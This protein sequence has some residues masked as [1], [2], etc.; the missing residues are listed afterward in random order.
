MSRISI[1]TATT[2]T[3]CSIPARVRRRSGISPGLG[4]SEAPWVRRSPA[5]GR[6]LRPAISTD[7]GKPDFVLYKA[8]TGQTVVW[9]LSNNVYAGAAFG[10][11]LAAGWSLAGVADFNRNGRTDYAL[12]KPSTRQTAIYYLSGPVF[13][14]SAF[15]PTIAIGY[16]LTGTADLTGNDKPDYGFTTPPPREQRSST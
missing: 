2:T 7:D 14:S 16:E 10:P 4:L 15:G 5:A 13:V 8:S 11:T 3:Q 6:W 9:Y 12:F 1:A